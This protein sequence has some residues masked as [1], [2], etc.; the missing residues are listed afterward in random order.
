MIYKQRSHYLTYFTHKGFWPRSK[1]NHK[2]ITL[3]TGMQKPKPMHHTIGAECTYYKAKV[4]PHTSTIQVR[5]K[6]SFTRSQN[7]CWIS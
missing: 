2:I 5:A 7:V 3:A 4:S 6:M 1:L